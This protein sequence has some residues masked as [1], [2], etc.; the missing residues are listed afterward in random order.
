MLRTSDPGWKFSDMVIAEMSGTGKAGRWTGSAQELHS[1]AIMNT[2]LFVCL[3]KEGKKSSSE[4]PGQLTSF[5]LYELS[6]VVPELRPGT[7]YKIP[8]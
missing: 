7:Y 6:C 8:P 2:T 5:K 4:P 3:L 1:R